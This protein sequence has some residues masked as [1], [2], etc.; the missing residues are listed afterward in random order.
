MKI[1][2]FSAKTKITEWDQCSV[3]EIQIFLNLTLTL[4]GSL[5]ETEGP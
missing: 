3:Q 1:L 4:A 2:N 5:G